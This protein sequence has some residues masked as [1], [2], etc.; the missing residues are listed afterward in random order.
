MH[1]T[2]YPVHFCRT[3]DK[4]KATIYSGFPGDGGFFPFWAR[5]CGCAECIIASDK[6]GTNSRHNQNCYKHSQQSGCFSRKT[7]GFNQALQTKGRLREAQVLNAQRTQENGNVVA[8]WPEEDRLTTL[9]DKMQ[10]HDFG[11]YIQNPSDTTTSAFYQSAA[12]SQS[13]TTPAV[14]ETNS[15]TRLL[16]TDSVFKGN[17]VVE[18]HWP[19]YG[20]SDEVSYH[21]Q[22]HLPSIHQTSSTKLSSRDPRLKSKSEKC[23]GSGV[24][25]SNKN[26]VYQGLFNFLPVSGTQKIF[27]DEHQSE[28]NNS[29]RYREEMEL[30]FLQGGTTTATSTATWWNVAAMGQHPKPGQ[31]PSIYREKRAPAL[32]EKKDDL[33]G[34]DWKVQG[35]WGKQPM[36]LTLSELPNKHGVNEK[37]ACGTNPHRT[38]SW[39]HTLLPHEK[40]WRTSEEKLQKGTKCTPKKLDS[41]D[42]KNRHGT[43]DPFPNGSSHRKKQKLRTYKKALENVQDA[44]ILEIYAREERIRNLKTLLAK[45]EQALDALRYQRKQSFSDELS[46][47]LVAITNNETPHGRSSDQNDIVE[48]KEESYSS[49]DANLA[50]NSLKRRWLKNWSD[51]D[52]LDHKPPEKIQKRNQTDSH[53]MPSEEGNQNLSN[54]EFTALEGL[55]RL[56]KD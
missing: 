38:F 46:G 14:N 39:N 24:F 4:S 28:D 1:E 8:V 12:R 6:M 15:F 23:N 54:A 37:I 55:V 2:V 40:A 45:Q 30:S 3:N 26:S 21:N 11:T 32:T 31:A 17:E 48:D 9:S 42:T 7:N 34:D 29:K 36:Q 33:S 50:G 53:G 13:A 44:K 52:Q 27:R 47:S 5:K 49:P 18:N 56:S 35:S 10:T 22:Q 43:E 25:T 16:N 19:W 20:T 51:E 41:F